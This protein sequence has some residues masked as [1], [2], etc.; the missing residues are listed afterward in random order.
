MFFTDQASGY[1]ETPL[2]TYKP[3]EETLAAIGSVSRL[4]CE[5]FVG[6]YYI[7]LKKDKIYI[8]KMYYDNDDL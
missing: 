6:M 2:A 4:F 7:Y 1:M 5:A 8:H 3:P